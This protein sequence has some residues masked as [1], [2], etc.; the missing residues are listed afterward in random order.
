V[1]KV[2]I[3]GD[4]FHNRN[5][6]NVRTMNEGFENLKALSSLFDVSL[7]VGNHDAYLKNSIDVSSVWIFSSLKNV[8]IIQEPT[9]MEINGLNCL[10]VPWIVDDQIFRDQLGNGDYGEIDY[11]FGHFEFHGGQMA[12]SKFKLKIGQDPKP[13]QA[14]VK[15]KIFSG[16]YH[17]SD[18][19]NEK[20]LYV[21]SP[22]QANFG[23]ADDK[24]FIW[25]INEDWT[26]DRIENTTSPVFEKIPLTEFIKDREKFNIRDNHVKFI[27]DHQIDDLKLQRLIDFMK[28]KE[29]QT[30][31]VV[32]SIPVDELED[33]DVQ[34]EVDNIPELIQRYIDSG[35]IKAPP[36]EI[37]I[38]KNMIDRLYQEA[39]ML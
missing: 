22:M 16:H 17:L 14:H 31:V 33:F 8:R 12:G 30:F 20:V 13:I 4:W 27:I 28:S 1:T 18:W 11:M 6:L 21:G 36:E 23:E 9:N 32:D 19:L 24:K 2:F 37:E 34:A 26:L 38:L 29:P 15:E 35:V 5:E 7:I 25:V 39:M 3:L 10:L